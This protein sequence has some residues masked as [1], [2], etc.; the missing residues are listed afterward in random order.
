MPIQIQTVVCGAIG[1]NAYI[2]RPRDRDDC[3]VIDPGDEYPKLSRAV[4]TLKVA[5]ILLTHGHFDHIMAVGPMA[6]AHN[7]PVY[8]G[9]EDMEMLNDPALNGRTELMGISRMEGPAL[10]AQPFGETLSAA[11]FDF[12][13]ILT[14][15]HS[16]GSACL[17]L[18]AEEV[19]FSGDTLFQAGFGRMDLHGGSPRH[20]RESLRR[21][22]TLPPETRVYPGH[23]MPTT[24]GDERSRYRL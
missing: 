5:A 20:M 11:G 1:E 24:I 4:G 10:S 6:E 9:S 18:P 15:G 16:K 14:P 23:G 3:V 2:V 8:L 21:L 22:F 19:L 17:Y 13:I 7:A 12:E